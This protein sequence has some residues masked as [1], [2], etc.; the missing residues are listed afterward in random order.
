MPGA[1]TGDWAAW[2]SENTA[3]VRRSALALARKSWSN[4]AWGTEMPGTTVHR[5]LG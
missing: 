2:S 4:T 5:Q 3:G 1:D